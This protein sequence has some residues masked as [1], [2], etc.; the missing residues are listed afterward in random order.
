MLFDA[1][2]KGML[3]SGAEVYDE[4]VSTTPSISYLVR[5]NI[6]PMAS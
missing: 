2:I 5:Q 3:A 6:S 4:D 1:I